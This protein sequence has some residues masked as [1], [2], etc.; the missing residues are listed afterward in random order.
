MEAALFQ[1]VIFISTQNPTVK[2]DIDTIMISWQPSNK[3]N[4]CD[5]KFL[6]LA[7]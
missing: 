6:G 4:L 7:E 2:A 1:K 3:K 5:V